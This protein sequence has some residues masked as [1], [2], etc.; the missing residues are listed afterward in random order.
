MLGVGHEAPGSLM[1]L[2]DSYGHMLCDC[3][4]LKQSD[5]SEDWLCRLFLTIYA[6]K[7]LASLILGSN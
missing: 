5:W 2:L 1:I 3:S 7:T 6:Q 4:Q